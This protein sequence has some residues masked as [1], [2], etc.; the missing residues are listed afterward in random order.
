MD[1]PAGARAGRAARPGRP[2]NSSCLS[3]EL[4]AGNT[5]WLCK[6]Q[7]PSPRDDSRDVGIHRE[8]RLSD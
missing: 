6:N 4:S 2:R 3:D 7:L 8:A 1:V 5:P